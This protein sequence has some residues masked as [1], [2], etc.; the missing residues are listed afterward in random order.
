MTGT[1][2]PDI[3]DPL[4][5]PAP[6]ELRETFELFARYRP[7]SG[8]AGLFDGID[9]LAVTPRQIYYA[10]HGRAPERVDHAIA[11]PAFSP[12]Q[13]FVA[14][15]AS[16]EFRDSVVR[17]LLHAFPER[18]RLLFLHIPR[19]AGS[20]LSVRL[21]SRYPSISSQLS[22]PGWMSWQDFY[23]TIQQ[24]VREAVSSDSIFVRGHNT[25]EQYR[26]WGTIRFR[27]CLFAV[28]RDP[29]EMTVSQV[30]YVLT[31]VYSR[32]VPPAPDT[33]AW[34]SR[35]GLADPVTPPSPPEAAALARRILRDQGVV[36]PNTICHDLGDAT[37]NRAAENVILHAVELTDFAH[38][39]EW[40][41]RRWGIDRQSRSNQS[42]SYIA[43]G[44]LTAEDRGH[45]AA[46]TAEDA[47]IYAVA[48]RALARSA[49]PSVTGDELL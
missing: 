9:L 10:V 36:L 2:G 44:D 16:K 33:A 13:G 18:K 47:K 3:V 38:Y 42:M 1:G 11:R 45:I 7:E 48:Q 32:A 6:A 31:R 39:D 8:I 41:R 30:N 25:L 22:W 34:R 46:I 37:A 12:L 14:A 35:F 43:L 21:M 40:C 28:L 26:A 15:L 27:D 24:F 5:P 49:G 20:E 17:N 19:T 29:I 23:L 4:R